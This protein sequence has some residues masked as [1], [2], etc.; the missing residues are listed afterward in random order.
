MSAIDFPNTPSSGDVFVD[1]VNLWQFDGVRWISIRIGS[2]NEGIIDGG[3][4][5][6][7]ST[8]RIFNA[9]SPSSTHNLPSI[10]CG[11]VS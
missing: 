8:F 10:D 3:S 11:S 9:G 5:S 6:D 1:G 2:P 7:L 4:P